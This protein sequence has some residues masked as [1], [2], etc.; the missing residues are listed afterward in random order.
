M[1]RAEW[2]RAGSCQDPQH[3]NVHLQNSPIVHLQDS[4]VTQG[5]QC[6][7]NQQ[8]VQKETRGSSTDV[9]PTI[10]LGTY[11]WLEFQ[12]WHGDGAEEASSKAPRVPTDAEREFCTM[13]HALHLNQ[14]LMKPNVDP[15]PMSP[16]FPSTELQRELCQ[17]AVPPL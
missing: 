4:S 17:S 14:Q 7:V 2:S 16:H 9:L 6:Q 1:I 11:T 8:Q 3:L 13:M 15:R 5:N 10:M 12:E